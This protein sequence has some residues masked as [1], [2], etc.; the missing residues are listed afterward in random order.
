MVEFH[1]D[2]R[3]FY[4]KGNKLIRIN[5]KNFSI[6]CILLISVKTTANDTTTDPISPCQR[7][8]TTFTT[9]TDSS[10]ICVIKKKV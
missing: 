10:R 8:H 2:D 7:N 3:C 6:Q 1:M 9:E 4:R 5:K